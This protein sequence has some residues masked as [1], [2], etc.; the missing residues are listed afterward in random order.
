M[1]RSYPKGDLDEFRAEYNKLIG[2]VDEESVAKVQK[3]LEGPIL[4]NA[5]TN[6]MNTLD[7]FLRTPLFYAVSIKN[8][9]IVKLLVEHGKAKANVQCTKKEKTPLLLAVSQKNH[10]IAKYLLTRA[11][12]N[13]NLASSD[14]NAPLTIAIRLQDLDMVDM[15]LRANAD[16][17]I[18][19]PTQ[20]TPLTYAVMNKNY[21]IVARLVKHGA[22][23]NDRRV[24]FTALSLATLQL[25]IKLVRFLI[26]KGA[27]VNAVNS[28]GTTAL[29]VATQL[30]NMDF[31][32]YL[33]R[34]GANVNTVSVRAGDETDFYTPLTNA[35]DRD[36]EDMVEYFVRKA[37]ADVNAHPENSPRTTLYH[38]LV[39]GNIRVIRLLLEHGA[40]MHVGFLNFYKT[41]G[42][43]SGTVYS[44]MR[45]TLLHLMRDIIQSR[46][47][48]E[49]KK[50]S[51]NKQP[52]P[53]DLV[54]M[55]SAYSEPT[56]EEI[57][58]LVLFQSEPYP[59]LPDLLVTV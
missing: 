36:N 12:A 57:Q 29:L 21:E 42:G 19:S 14:G 28:N 27:D 47:T 45:G 37:G 3:L 23:V 30:E 2:A 17:N 6:K 1:W 41:R 24:K 4:K 13:P 7:E 44:M 49:L 5:S 59:M 56:W 15:L 52:I 25:S 31:V 51:A 43:I 26:E 54:S 58:P 8:Y 16:S 50:L 40:K 34:K 46:R 10:L 35:V 55:V 39:K 53:M 22:R 9:E 18:L 38:A 32:Q 33:I 48:E 20:M 11:K